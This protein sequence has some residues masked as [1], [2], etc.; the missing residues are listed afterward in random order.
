ML[1]I[2]TSTTVNL[3]VYVSNQVVCSTDVVVC[4][5]YLKYL[6]IYLSLYILQSKS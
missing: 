1:T 5:T 3:K 2:L 4:L 6:F